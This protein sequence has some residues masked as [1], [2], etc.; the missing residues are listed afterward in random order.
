MAQLRINITDSKLVSNGSFW[1][2]NNTKRKERLKNITILKA[3]TIMA[4]NNPEF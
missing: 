1:T 3:K 4:L 2:T